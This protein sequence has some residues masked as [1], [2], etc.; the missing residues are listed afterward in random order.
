MNHATGVVRGAAVPT[1]RTTINL[2]S[3][4]RRQTG[5]LNS[6]SARSQR[7]I[8]Q[9]FA[10]ELGPEIALAKIR[11]KHIDRWLA[12]QICSAS[13]G[14]VRL[15][16]V[17]TFFKWCVI[18]EHCRHDPTAGVRGP[19]RPQTLPRTITATDV[20][21]LLDHCPDLRARVIVLL[22]VQEGLRR[23]EIA[24]LDT[25]S[26]DWDDQTLTVRGKFDKE[27]LIPVSDETKAAID[28]YLAEDPAGPHRPLLRSVGNRPGRRLAPA[29]I[30]CLARKIFDDAGVKQAAWDGKSLHSLRHAA[31]CDMLTNGGDPRDVADF[32]G[33]ADSSFT[34][35]VYGRRHAAVTRLKKASEGRSYTPRLS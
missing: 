26:F 5:E 4:T 35:R 24:S 28:V 34:L 16:V 17:R 10:D 19:R 15:S 6:L 32:L 22:G 20:G 13:T 11:R 14:G 2:Y 25:T 18:H 31:A 12:A 30:S 1:L 21:K 23:S 8:L 3:H 29:T 9:A 27:R 33:H 7:Y